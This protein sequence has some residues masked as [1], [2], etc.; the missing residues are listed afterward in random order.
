M[1]GSSEGLASLQG[2]SARIYG[3][4]DYG[5][6]GISVA[7]I[8]DLSH[9]GKVDLAIGAYGDKIDAASPEAPGAVHIFTHTPQGSALVSDSDLTLYGNGGG[10]GYHVAGLSDADG[11]TTSDLLVGAYMEGGGAGYLFSGGE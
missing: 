5:Y 1:L 4:T 9:D 2:A 6:T 3:S 8:D 11:D 7:F 10:F